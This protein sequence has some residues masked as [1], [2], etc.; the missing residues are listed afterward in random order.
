[1]RPL[2]SLVA[3]FL[4]GSAALEAQEPE[5]KEFRSPADGFSVLLPGTPEIEEENV[6]GVPTRYFTVKFNQRGFNVT[7][8]DAG[9][10]IP[11]SAVDN[12]M[13]SSRDHMA[14]GFNGTVSDERPIKCGQHPGRRFLI[15]GPDSWAAIQLCVA[16]SRSYMLSAG[17]RRGP[18]PAEIVARFHNSF[19]LFPIAGSAASQAAPQEL[20]WKGFRSPPDGFSVLFPGDPKLTEQKDDE[21]IIHRRFIVQLKGR[22]FSVHCADYGEPAQPFA[23]Q[24]KNVGRD[25]L[26]N[27]VKGKVSEERPAKCGLYPGWR[28]VITTPDTWFAYQYCVAG[29]RSYMALARSDG[30]PLPPEVVAHFHDSFKLFRPAPPK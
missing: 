7:V 16:G 25:A 9:Q 5:W 12:L 3:L 6:N 1:M 30:G 4:L 13:N 17:S 8:S 18:W 28:I 19:Q 10:P 24:L 11:P 26:V 21:G 29:N 14:A 27:Y 22:Q 23:E 15:T 2:C 20:V